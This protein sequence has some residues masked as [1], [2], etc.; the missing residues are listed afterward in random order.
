M[1]LV[2]KFI[3]FLIILECFLVV[4]IVRGVISN[5]DFVNILV[6]VFD[7]VLIMYK[8]ILDF[9]IRFFFLFILVKMFKNFELYVSESGI[10]LKCF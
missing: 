5:K 7:I 10:L 8:S 6:F 4:V 2:L 1:I 9:W 3:N